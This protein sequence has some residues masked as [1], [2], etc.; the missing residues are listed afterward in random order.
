[1]FYDQPDIF[2]LKKKQQ[3]PINSV[4]QEIYYIPINSLTLHRN[5]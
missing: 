2:M 5:T 4:E 1:M 3:P